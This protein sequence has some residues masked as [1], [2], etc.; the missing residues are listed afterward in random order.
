MR[1]IVALALCGLPLAQAA[2]ARPIAPQILCDAYPDAPTCVGSKPACVFCHVVPPTRNAFGMA[3]EAA[4]L[5]GEA[6]PLSEQAFAANLPSALAAVE[7]ADTDG[8]GYS[9]RDEIIA[10]TLPADPLNLPIDPACG[11]KKNPRWDLCNYDRPYVFRKL[12]IDFCGRSPSFEDLTAFTALAEA[13][14]DTALGDALSG[15]LDSDYWLGQ[16]GALWKLAHRKIR[17]LRAIKS[18]ADGGV[19][20]LA[21]CFDDYAL[22]AYANTDDRD[23]RDLLKADYFARRV[24]GSPTSYERVDDIGSQDV[25]RARRA[26]M[27]TT[28]WNLM[29]HVMFTALPRTAAAQVYR[30]YLNLD[31]AKLQGL[32]PVDNE[33]VDYDGKDVTE[34]ACVICHSTLDPLS[35]PFK[36]Y[37][38]LNDSPFGTYDP[39]RIE[40][41]FSSE[42]PNITQMPE[43]GVIFGQPVNDLIEWAAVAAETEEF[44]RAVVED[45]W[46]LL[47]GTRPVL[48]EATELEGLW[49][50]LMN[51]HR[52]QVE[53]MLHALIR[54]EAY[55]AP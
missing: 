19:I 38:G 20:P 54:T 14:Q 41:Q 31:I 37:N 42:A 18:G 21:D 25:A 33:P 26:G 15:C 6:R 3:L 8:D 34:P 35:Y 39:R 49:R 48:A 30:G 22:F 40:R 11:D 17:P 47:I 29:Y 46:M 23:V 2:D 45:Y 1:N 50:G 32:R 51:E 28:K 55:G 16:D 36:N 7:G 53:K 10:G 27:I 4:L 44:A 43:Q 24:D 9:N 5:P 12:N 13:E 52:Y